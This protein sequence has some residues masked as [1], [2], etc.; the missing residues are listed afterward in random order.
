[1]ARRTPL[2]ACWLLLAA[3][4]AGAYGT[5]AE[6]PAP[7]GW[8]TDAAGAIEATR[9]HHLDPVEAAAER[10]ASPEGPSSC[11]SDCTP[12]SR[13]CAASPPPS[14][15]TD[16]P[17]EAFILDQYAYH[18][19]LIDDEMRDKR[20][21]TS[22]ALAHLG[23]DTSIDDDAWTMEATAQGLLVCLARVAL[24]PVVQ[25]AAYLWG[26]AQVVALACA[27]E[28]FVRTARTLVDLRDEGTPPDPGTYAFL[29]GCLVPILRP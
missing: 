18:L 6:P 8:V 20:N 2:L 19:W 23:Q 11:L 21:T 10:L 25:D 26:P 9:D 14:P 16:S 3:P 13:W 1:M 15:N 12:E 24:D 17:H 22:W 27:S 4:L 29:P 7:I 28:A 5:P